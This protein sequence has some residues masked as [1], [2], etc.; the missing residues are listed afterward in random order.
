MSDQT[1]SVVI[2]TFKGVDFIADS[3][4]S[5][6]AQSHPADEIVIVDDA[7]PDGTLEAARAAA[8]RSSVPVKILSMPQNSGGPGGPLNRGIAAASGRYIATLD[9]DDAMEP[10]RLEWQL[11]C[12]RRGSDIGL[13]IGRL[14][15]GAMGREFEQY[16][17]ERE[18]A[19]W[20][21]P[22]QPLG[23]DAYR[24]PS[25]D[26]YNALLR[27]GCYGFSCSTFLFPKAV[28]Q[29]VGGFD[30]K[31]KASCDYAFMEAVLKTHD[32][33]L[34]DAPVASWRIHPASFSRLKDSRVFWN[35]LT[36]IYAK[37]DPSRLDRDAA[38]LRT[39]AH[40]DLAEK[41]SYH[42]R[43]AGHYWTA[44][45]YNWKLMTHGQRPLRGLV[46]LLKLPP[47]YLLR[48]LRPRSHQ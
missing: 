47:H 30:E 19:L 39:E 45:R 13:V 41:A 16:V 5:V 7:S 9:Q 23:G 4:A 18:A 40:A 48:R 22:V 12:A 11:D 6:F 14:V 44:C 35:D 20:K 25:R 1:I 43:D 46:G 37:F 26:A 34:V 31:V 27:I 32:L 28:W 8:S 21:L 36:R 2:P 42:S 3:L 33:G 15:R 10:R 17:G 24:L 38:A 29:E